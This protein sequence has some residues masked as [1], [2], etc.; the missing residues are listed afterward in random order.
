MV[1]RLVLAIGLFATSALATEHALDA[2]VQVY[3]QESEL[4]CM[5][6]TIHYNDYSDLQSSVS[7]LSS[8]YTFCS[9]EV[10]ARTV[11][12]ESCMFTTIMYD[13]AWELA[14]TMEMLSVSYTTCGPSF[15]SS[16]SSAFPTGSN[17]TIT[18]TF[19]SSQ[20]TI[21]SASF[22]LTNSSTSTQQPTTTLAPTYSAPP[23]TAGACSRGAAP[24]CT[25]SG[26][27]VATSGLLAVATGVAPATLGNNGPAYEEC[28]RICTSVQGC[29]SW[30]LDRN[31]A[32]DGTWTCY[33]YSGAV[34][35]YAISYNGAYSA[36]VWFASG[37]YTCANESLSA[38]V[39]S[40][41]SS[42]TSSSSTSSSSTFSAPACSATSGSVIQ[43]GGFENWSNYD[44][45][46]NWTNIGNA[47]LY[48]ESWQSVD[49][50]YCV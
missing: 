12:D 32:A 35:T 48:Q 22:S 13:E 14:T 3:S 39:S 5:Y 19:S 50:Q 1:S 47:E 8:S 42:S 46:N 4:S 29:N 27:P 44:A 34:N 21:T 30:N 10:L 37:C 15:T 7:S 26:A 18:S 49:G 17:S 40:T 25:L 38:P 2:R 9:N 28:A 33:V 23:Y 11:S 36:T 16:S 45:V 20:P 41:S 31:A 6:T 24:S 43:N